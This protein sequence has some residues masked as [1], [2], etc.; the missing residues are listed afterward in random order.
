MNTANLTIENKKFVYRK[1]AFVVKW[2]CGKRGPGKA[3]VTGLINESN[4]EWAHRVI[5]LYL[6]GWRNDRVTGLHEFCRLANEK[7]FVQ[8][9]NSLG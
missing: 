2:N 7:G 1:G 3:K 5:N 6:K 9:L 4:I 8:A